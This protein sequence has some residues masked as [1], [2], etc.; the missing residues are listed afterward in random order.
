[1]LRGLLTKAVPLAG[2]NTPN[3]SDIQYGV[4]NML[5]QPYTF[6]SWLSNI[7]V[8]GSTMTRKQ[9]QSEVQTSSNLFSHYS[10]TTVANTEFDTNAVTK[11]C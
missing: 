10:V 11:Q 3:H 8:C 9:A 1:M 5:L 7:Y 2:A 4:F 6:V